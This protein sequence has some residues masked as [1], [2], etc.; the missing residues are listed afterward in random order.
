MN[1]VKD[2]FSGI[3]FSWKTVFGNWNYSLLALVIA[4]FFYIFNALL[5]NITN[6]WDFVK[7]LGVKQTLIYVGNLIIGFKAT[8]LDHSFYNVIALSLLTGIL[9]S[10]MAYKYK[11][12]SMPIKKKDGVFGGFV[13]F[14][15]FIVPGCASCGIGLLALL[16]LGSALASLPFGGQEVTILATVLMIFVIFKFS[17]DI[18]VC[19]NVKS[20]E[21]IEN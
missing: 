18:F 1:K 7:T 13:A 11:M 10:L 2:Y 16:G 8:L 12:T 4:G 15:A 14:L 21:F 5:N 9:I 6:I 3:W 19:K 20:T 17:K